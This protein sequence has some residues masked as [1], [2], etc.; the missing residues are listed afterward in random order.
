MSGFSRAPESVAAREQE[1]VAFPQQGYAAVF[2]DLHDHVRAG[3]DPAAL[4]NAHMMSVYAGLQRHIELT[5]TS[6]LP[7]FDSKNWTGPQVPMNTV[8]EAT[9]INT[10]R[11]GDYL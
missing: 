4:D 7:P 6:A 8:T 3:S 9:L 10:A 11:G 2:A 1:V 5:Q